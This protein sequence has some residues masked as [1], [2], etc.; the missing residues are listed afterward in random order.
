MKGTYLW[1][2]ESNSNGE[3]GGV[4]SHTNNTKQFLDTS[5]MF[6]IQLNSDSIYPETISESTG[7]RFSPTT[8]TTYF[9]DQSQV[10]VINC[11]PDPAGSRPRF[12]EPLAWVG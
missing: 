11:T 10:Q 2:S 12:P 4:G 5:R 1:Y 8:V 7:K 3:H 9:I 6:E